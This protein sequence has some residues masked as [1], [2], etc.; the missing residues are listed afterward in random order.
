LQKLPLQPQDK[1]MVVM[2]HIF[3]YTLN[4]QQRC[5]KSSLVVLGEDAVRTAMAKTVGLP[6]AV[7]AKLIL[8]NK[9]KLTGVQ[10]PNHPEIYEPILAELKTHGI[11]FVEED[12][13]LTK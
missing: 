8:E 13:V 9:I 4:Q 6:L 7:G 3:E 1:D 10:I 5:F 12:E 2:Q 11:Y